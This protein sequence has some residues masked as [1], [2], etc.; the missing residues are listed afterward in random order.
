MATNY[1]G[2]DYMEKYN[3]EIEE[4]KQV[5]DEGYEDC[6][7]V[8]DFGRVRSVDRVIETKRGPVRFRGR[9]ISTPL[10]SD[11]YPALMLCKAG[12][13]KH[14]KVHQ[15]V[16][17]AFIPNPNNLPEINHIDEVKDNNHATNL[18]WC[19]HFY[20]MNHG[21]TMKRMNEHPNQIKR[22]NESKKPIVG[23]KDRK[24]VV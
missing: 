11:G 17:R 23:I 18:E 22:F 9:D 20:N 19:T 24:S 16:A 7:E 6:Y 2:V 4:W 5:A 3:T 8:S 12:N 14:V 15:L 10:N 1:I 13:K 21:T